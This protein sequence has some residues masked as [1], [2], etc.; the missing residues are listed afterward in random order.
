MPLANLGFLDQAGRPDSGLLVSTGPTIEV[1]VSSLVAPDGLQSVAHPI[2]ALVDT[3][4]TLSCI[5]E[6][7]ASTLKLPVIDEMTIGGASG[8]RKHDVYAARV[9]IPSLEVEQ[10]GAFAGVGLAA[11]GQLH[12][13][14]LGRTFLQGMVMIYDGIRAQVTIASARLND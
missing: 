10:H 14:L 7:L 12:G 1:V 5:D 13:V 4:A 3:G 9:T 2:H 8:A 11:G 6:D